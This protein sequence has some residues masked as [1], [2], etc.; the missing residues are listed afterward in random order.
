[1]FRLLTSLPGSCKRM[2]MVSNILHTVKHYY[3][4]D[5]YVIQVLR[6]LYKLTLISTTEL[7]VR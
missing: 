2:G 1:M 3:T 4:V 5:L 6:P 7:N